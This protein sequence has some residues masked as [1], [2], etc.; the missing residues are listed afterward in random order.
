[1]ENSQAES[2]HSFPNVLSIIMEGG[3][4]HS[5]QYR[6]LNDRC[7]NSG[8][9]ERYRSAHSCVLRFSLLKLNAPVGY[10]EDCVDL[11][12]RTP[13]EY[14]NTRW[15]TTLSYC[16]LREFF[17]DG[18]TEGTKLLESRTAGLLQDDSLVRECILEP[19]RSKE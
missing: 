7:L 9:I 3:A 17:F 4:S 19:P 10:N 6:V 16:G 15:T 1:M 2:H 12:Q 11:Y 14:D 18:V 8:G 5:C 13:E